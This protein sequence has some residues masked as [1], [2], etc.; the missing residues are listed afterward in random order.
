MS[1]LSAI[2]AFARETAPAVGFDEGDTA[3]ILLALEEAITDV[4]EHAY[5]EGEQ[6]FFEVSIRAPHNRSENNREG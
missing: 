5:E 3:K 1:C 4:I 6:A 2:Q